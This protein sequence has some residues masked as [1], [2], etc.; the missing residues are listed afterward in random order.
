MQIEWER[1]HRRCEL[2]GA[3]RN[4]HTHHI[5]PR[6]RAPELKENPKNWIRL[7]FRCH[8]AIHDGKIDLNDYEYVLRDRF[9]PSNWKKESILML[10]NSSFSNT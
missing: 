10:G 7:C 5:I 8:R 9:R 4:L 3:T 2:C 1:H 6:S